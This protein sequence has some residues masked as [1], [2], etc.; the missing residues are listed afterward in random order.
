MCRHAVKIQQPEILFRHEKRKADTWI[1][2]WISGLRK[3][4]SHWIWDMKSKNKMKQTFGIKFELILDITCQCS[5]VFRSSWLV[6]AIKKEKK[7]QETYKACLLMNVEM[8]RAH[9]SWSNVTTESQLFKF[10]TLI[11]RWN[12]L[13]FCQFHTTVNNNRLNLIRTV[14]VQVSSSFQ[15]LQISVCNSGVD[16][17]DT[18]SS[19]SHDE[20]PSASMLTRVPHS[21]SRCAF[22]A[23]WWSQN[24]FKEGCYLWS[25]LK[26]YSHFSDVRLVEEVMVAPQKLTV[27]IINEIIS[28]VVA[29]LLQTVAAVEL[30][31]WLLARPQPPNIISIWNYLSVIALTLMIHFIIWVIHKVLHNSIKVTISWRTCMSL[32]T[33][34]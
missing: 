19:C 13:F 14:T 24:H 29:V 30:C 25:H 26:K 12:K 9:C 34:G 28:L 8:F 22:G 5:E 33:A 18:Q 16:W 10:V 3:C 4:P 11:R 6:M 15:A 1:F 2:C 17:N 27:W 7:H 20:S 21:V 32:C 31:S 23:Q